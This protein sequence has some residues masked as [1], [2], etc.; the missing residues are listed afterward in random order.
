[1]K[2]SL[3][4]LKQLLMLSSTTISLRGHLDWESADTSKTHP[5]SL[6]SSVAPLN[7]GAT[8][9]YG[10][11]LVPPPALVCWPALAAAPGSFLTLVMCSWAERSRPPSV[12]SPMPGPM[13]SAGQKIPGDGDAFV[14]GAFAA[15]FSSARCLLVVLVGVTFGV[16]VSGPN[17]VDGSGVFCV[18]C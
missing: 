14:V 11:F 12:T 9:L 10:F 4:A 8:G 16:F 15:D 1:M 3:R 5:F 7:F 2:D 6:S 17:N 13:P 18:L